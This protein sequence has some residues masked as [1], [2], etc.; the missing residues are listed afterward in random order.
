LIAIISLYT[1]G[2][3]L[4][5]REHFFARLGCFEWAV[6]ILRTENVSQ[7]CCQKSSTKEKLD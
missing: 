2:A 5:A 1:S 7:T 4:C 3:K 6:Q